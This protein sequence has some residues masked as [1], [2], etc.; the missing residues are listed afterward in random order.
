MV[1]GPD[2]ITGEFFQNS[3]TYV[4][5]FLVWYLNKFFS[6]GTYPDDW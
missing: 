2:L 6:L 4:V 3:A 1:A 5:P